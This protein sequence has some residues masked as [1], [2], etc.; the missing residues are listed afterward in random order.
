VKQE[1]VSAR[2]ELGSTTDELTA[3]KRQALELKTVIAFSPDGRVVASGNWDGSVILWDPQTRQPVGDP[4]R[5]HEDG[6][7]SVAFSPNG[8]TLA[9][10]DSNGSVILWDTQRGQ[11]IGEPLIG[12]PLRRDVPDVFSVA[13]SPDGKILASGGGAVILWDT[14]S[15]QQ[16]G[17]LN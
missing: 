16:I 11:Q 4:L 6:V 2:D 1:L 13:F 15:R 14:Q 7:Q 8:R 5:G 10:G 3:I 9:S 12:E 17:E